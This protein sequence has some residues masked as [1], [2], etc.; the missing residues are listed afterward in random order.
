MDEK[1][2]KLR[3]KLLLSLV[4]AWMTIEKV[5]DLK[6]K[7]VP[8]SIGNLLFT[9]K[10][11]VPPSVLSVI[12]DKACQE[13]DSG[14]GPGVAVSRLRAKTFADSGKIDHEGKYTIYGQ[15]I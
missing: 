9:S 13:V 10:Y 6:N 15:L 12:V 7:N 8:G 14:Y 4:K 1:A 11:L 2:V 5:T 3:C